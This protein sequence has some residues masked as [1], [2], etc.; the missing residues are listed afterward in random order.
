MC[1]KAAFEAEL[2]IVEVRGRIVPERSARWLSALI[3]RSS[4]GLTIV[5]WC[6]GC[7]SLAGEA[8]GCLCCTRTCRPKSAVALPSGLYHGA[9]E[10]DQAVAPQRVQGRHV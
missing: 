4:Q 8:H 3:P 7:E 6:V 5:V 10:H 9:F 1:I 2:A